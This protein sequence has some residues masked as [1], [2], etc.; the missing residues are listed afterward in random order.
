MLDGVKI[1]APMPRV[2][3]QPEEAGTIRRSIDRE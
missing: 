1:P 2:I 3:S